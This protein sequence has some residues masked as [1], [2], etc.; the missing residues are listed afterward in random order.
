MHKKEVLIPPGILAIKQVG[1]FQNFRPLVDM[2]YLDKKLYKLPPKEVY[3]AY[4]GDRKMKNEQKKKIKDMAQKNI[5][6][7]KRKN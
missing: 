2:E 5:K 1:M 4:Q 3:D 7:K 6:K